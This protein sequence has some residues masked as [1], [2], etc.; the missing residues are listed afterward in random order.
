[1][2]RS[3]QSPNVEELRM[4]LEQGFLQAMIENAD[5]DGVRLI[6]ADWLEE[7]G[8]PR[9]EFIRI[10]VDRARPS[11]D[12]LRQTMNERRES[13]L[14]RAHE[15]EWVAPLRPWVREWRFVRGFVE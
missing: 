12:E 9:G 7:R 3:R 6:L 2:T 5:D 15:K 11:L 1:M 14:L 13:E 10:Q 4:S 8:D